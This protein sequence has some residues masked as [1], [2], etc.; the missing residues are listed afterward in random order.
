[1]KKSIYALIVAVSLL[2]SS[3][4]TAAEE[5]ACYL[6]DEYIGYCFEAQEAFGISAA[7]IASIIQ[8]ESSG[9]EDVKAKNCWGL[10]QVQTAHVY[11]PNDL[12]DAEQNIRFGVSVLDECRQR[13]ERNGYSEDVVLALLYYN[14]VSNALEVYENWLEAGNYDEYPTD[15][16]AKVLTTAEEIEKE[17]YE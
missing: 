15:Y 10:M 4:T 5:K 8:T 2:S 13:A 17:W 7:L 1:M 14:G 3:I 12:L 6:P 16:V 9:I 11:D